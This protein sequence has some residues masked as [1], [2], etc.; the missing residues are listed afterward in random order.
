MAENEAANPFEVTASAGTDSRSPRW[1][2]SN[3]LFAVSVWLVCLAVFANRM[4]ARFENGK[5]YYSPSTAYS[6]DIYLHSVAY[7]DLTTAALVSASL[8]L[9][10]FGVTHGTVFVLRRILTPR[11]RIRR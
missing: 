3:L 4:E 6:N 10:I 8:L 7:V 5:L 11:V 9:A 2:I 1:L